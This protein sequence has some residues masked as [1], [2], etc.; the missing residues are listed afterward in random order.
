MNFSLFQKFE[1][2]NTCKHVIREKIIHLFTPVS[3]PCS[4]AS[5]SHES[6]RNAIRVLYFAEF[7]CSRSKFGECLWVLDRFDCF[8]RGLGCGIGCGIR[9]GGRSAVHG[10]GHFE[11]LFMNNESI[12]FFFYLFQCKINKY[13]YINIS[14]TIQSNDPTP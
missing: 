1:L 5:V 12:Q 13:K 3:T 6:M 4:A 9:L 2:V 8:R 14:Y 7:Q 11:N 10:C